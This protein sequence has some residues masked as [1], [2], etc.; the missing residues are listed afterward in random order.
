[1]G[2]TATADV[3]L[4]VPDY[5]DSASLLSVPSSEDSPMSLSRSSS[6]LTLY[7]EDISGSLGKQRSLASTPLSSLSIPSHKRFSKAIHEH[8]IPRK[9]MHVSIG[10]LTMWLYIQGVQL[11][12]VTPVLTALLVVIG[13]AD[14]LR[15][16]IPEFNQLYVRYM[17]FLMRE[18]EVSQSYNGVIWYLV[19]LIA[20]FLVFPKDISLLAVLLLSWADTAAS[21]VGRRFG[22][23]TPKIGNKSLAGSLAAFAAGIFSA[24]LIY[25]VYLPLYDYNNLPG[26][27]LWKPQESRVSFPLLAVVIGIAGAASEAVDF[28]D[29]NLTIPV[30]SASCIWAFVKLTNV[31]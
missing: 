23:Y 12:Q 28:V 19:G 31:S 7:D 14:I 17:G 29:D 21:T 2:T 18:K 11:V 16:R 20:V 5:A 24:W 27:I 8:E 25:K 10:F 30:L 13:S 3:Y 26:D 4:R 1:M 15:F 6:D 22:K 9:V